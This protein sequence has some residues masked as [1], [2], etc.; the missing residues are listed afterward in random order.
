M[1][2]ERICTV[3]RCAREKEMYIWV[4]RKEGTARLPGELLQAA[5]TLS[6]VLTLRLG[7]ERRLARAKA[8]EVLAA[9]AERGYYLQLPPDKQVTRFTM[10]E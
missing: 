9:I 7:P 5:G 1:S 10:G 8:S 2:D 6:E 3:Y 4:D